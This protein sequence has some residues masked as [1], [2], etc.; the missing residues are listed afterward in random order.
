[1]IYMRYGKYI[2]NRSLHVG[3]LKD[4]LVTELWILLDY[5]P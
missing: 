2:H 3:L 5:Y 4:K 1:M